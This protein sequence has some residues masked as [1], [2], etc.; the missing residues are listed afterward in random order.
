MTPSDFKIDSSTRLYVVIGH[1]VGHSLS[2]QLHNAA[3][4]SLGINAVYIALEV[5]PSEL[6]DAVKGLRAIGTAGFNVTL[7]H[8]EAI[9]TMLDQLDQ[10]AEKIMAVNTVYLRD[11]K[12][13]GY[14]T[15][16]AGF[17]A[18][19]QRLGLDLLTTEAVVVGAGGV[20]HA[21]VEGLLSLGCKK[22]TVLNRSIDRAK[23][24][25]NLAS[26]RD[27]VKAS[28]LTESILKQTLSNAVLLVNATPVGMAP[29]T[30]FSIVP[31]NLLRS[32][33]VVY[34]LVYSPFETKLLL[35]ARE[36]GAKIV[37]GYMMLLEQAARSFEIWTGFEAPRKVMQD[38][39]LRSL[40]VVKC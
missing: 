34:D 9:V 23:Q 15:D 38:V 11:R 40:G 10:S 18:P 14:N 13:Y 25:V 29:Y 8:K 31:K 39:L 26:R 22:I 17:I 16:V 20:A 1:P 6:I 37:P 2:P 35:E 28:K 7:P 27:R 12:L 24:L 33:M 36:V 30:E 3:F 5:Y 32:D 21:C 4:R 19:L